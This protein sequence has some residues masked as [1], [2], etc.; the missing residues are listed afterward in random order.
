MTRIAVAATGR[1]HRPPPQPPPQHPRAQGGG[2]RAGAQPARDAIVARCDVGRRLHC[3]NKRARVLGRS[4]RSPRTSTSSPIRRSARARFVCDCGR[5][6]PPARRD[7]M[8]GEPAAAPSDRRHHDAPRHSL[9]DNQRRTAQQDPPPSGGRSG[10]LRR[11]RGQGPPRGRPRRARDAR[12]R[13]RGAA[14]RAGHR[15]DS[16]SASTPRAFGPRRDDPIAM[17]R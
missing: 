13:R 4:P 1:W 2:P 3:V 10:P 8:C 17:Q 12:H 16:S 7:R 11:V 6:R 5:P 14:R 15:Q 9:T